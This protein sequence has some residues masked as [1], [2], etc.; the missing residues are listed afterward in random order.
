MKDFKFKIISAILAVV[1]VSAMGLSSCAD[2]GG[3]AGNTE[4]ESNSESGSTVTASDAE[5]IKLFGDGSCINVIFSEASR[6]Y[7]SS[8]GRAI[9][10]VY[11]DFPEMLNDGEHSADSSVF[12]ILIGDTNRAESDYEVNAEVTDAHYFVGISGNK[13]VINANSDYM[14]E[15][16]V[17]YFVSE[18]L[19]AAEGS[20]FTFTKE[21]NTLC[22]ERDFLDSRWSFDRIP[23]YVGASATYVRNAYDAGGL[24]SERGGSDSESS[25]VHKVQNTTPDEFE[26]YVERL[27]SVGFTETEREIIDS[28]TYVTLERG[29]ERVHTYFLGYNKSVSVIYETAGASVKDVSTFVTAEADKGAVIYQYGLNMDPSS[30]EGSGKTGYVNCGMLYI[31]KLADNS[32]I[33]IDGGNVEQ[34]AGLSAEDAPHDDLN[35]FLHE[36]TGVGENEKITVACWFV[37]HAH[38]DHADG[39]PTFISKHASEYDVKAVCANIPAFETANASALKMK[40]LFTAY[41]DCKEVKLHTGQ[42]LT[43]G[44]VTMQVL[45][46]HED[47]LNPAGNSTLVGSDFNG[48]STVVKLTAENMSMMVLGDATSVNESFLVNA[49]SDA[50]LKCDILQVAHHGF[51]DLPDLYAKADAKIAFIPQSYGYFFAPPSNA[52]PTHLAGM[53]GIKKS[54]KALIDS[55]KVY[56]AGNKDQTVGV[57]YRN[58]ELTVIRPS[59]V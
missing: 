49:Y 58:G 33:I 36:I 8:I 47:A 26:A 31:V 24:T 46:T 6:S 42:R 50:T 30:A 41:P 45:Y 9:F 55:G 48:T 40:T 32:L 13:L 54:I 44:D 28:N 20:S 11:G 23:A 5:S 43:F 59:D 34:M 22:V 53:S 10:N 16:A 25:R 4:T 14:L 35:A 3:E 52:E 21:M 56:F 19:S 29:G 37:T 7:A 38:G 27:V 18:C 12:E 15:C 39:F 51:N 1:L 57:A 17:E 2:R